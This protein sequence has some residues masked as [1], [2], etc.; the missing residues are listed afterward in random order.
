MVKHIAIAEKL[1][2]G[3]RRRTLKGKLPPQTVMAEQYDVSP[4]TMGK[5]LTALAEE[6][7]IR[8][9]PGLGTFVSEEA[10]RRTTLAVMMGDLQGHLHARI[11][12]AVQEEAAADEAEILVRG[13]RNSRH[14]EEEL[15][16]R[17]IEDRRVGG[18]IVWSISETLVG[19]LATLRGSQ[20][21]FVLVVNPGLQSDQEF[22]YVINDDFHGA[23]LAVEHLAGLGHRQIAWVAPEAAPLATTH[24]S[25]RLKGC[26]HAMRARGLGVPGR[27]TLGHSNGGLSS[28][29]TAPLKQF[30]GLVCYNDDAAWAAMQALRAEGLSV[31]GDVS[32]VGYDDVDVAR[33]LGITTVHQPIEEM[34]A[35]AVRILLGQIEDPDA[36]P[37]HRCLKPELV[38]RETTGAVRA[39]RVGGRL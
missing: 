20:M 12:A 35:E 5:A 39:E 16:R 11:L 9:K 22:S 14:D 27:V 26:E 1:R 33:T 28:D 10:A 24:G 38:V 21:P 36:G 6:G 18:L 37:V 23:V 19:H 29:E 7:L 32:V 4:T 25:A 15:I 3:I 34:G 17:Y 13:T 8:R 30:T 2:E 31:P